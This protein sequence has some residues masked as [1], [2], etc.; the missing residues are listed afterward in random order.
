MCIRDSITVDPAGPALHASVVQ[1]LRDADAVGLPALVYARPGP[2]ANE[3]LLRSDSP[4]AVRWLFD[5]AGAVPWISFQELP[6]D[7]ADWPVRDAAGNH[8]AAELAV[9]WYAAGYG[10]DLPQAEATSSA[11]VE[12]EEGE[13]AC[14]AGGRQT[15]ATT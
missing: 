9:T 5:T 14:G 6:G 12:S 7:P 11:V 1:A 2:E 3:A 15:E 8:Y 10:S 13:T 4:L